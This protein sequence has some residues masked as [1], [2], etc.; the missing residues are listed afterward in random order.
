VRPLRVALLLLLALA[1]PARA[2][3]TEFTS[4]ALPPE[5]PPATV[6][7]LVLAGSGISSFGESRP[8]KAKKDR[9]RVTDLTNPEDRAGLGPERA[10]ILLR[11]LTVPGWG[12]ASM[13]HRH[14]AAYFA[15]AEAGIWSA[16][17]A[18][19][20][21]E[22]LRRQSYERTAQLFAGIDLR[23]RDE[24]YRRIVGA[25]VSSEEYNLLVVS[26]DAANIYL[27]NLKNPDIAGYHAY[28]AA[29]SLSGSDA[30]SWSD[31]SSFERYRAQRKNS[32]RA[33]LRANTALGLAIANRLVSALHAARVAGRDLS[34]HP[35]TSW[36]L[37]VAPGQP[38]ERVL[39]RA[40]LRARF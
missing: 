40:G 22:V 4:A 8:K 31:G 7:P 29:H 14:A 25:F 33:A 1:V 21:Q 36:N 12:Q 9:K 28:I 39:A 38:G 18:F 2:D 16:F 20:V 13:G 24:E 6:S 10:R 32:Q 35:R 17:S 23:G 19:R 5:P 37:D 3:V 34:A 30:W 27:R 26:R 11:S 15:V